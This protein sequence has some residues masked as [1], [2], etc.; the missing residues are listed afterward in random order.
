MFDL[1]Y[2]SNTC[3]YYQNKRTN[4]IRFWKIK[5]HRYCQRNGMK[6]C[7]VANFQGQTSDVYAY[8]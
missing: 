4:K 3:P 8:V 2:Y 6:E 5:S 1:F 7:E